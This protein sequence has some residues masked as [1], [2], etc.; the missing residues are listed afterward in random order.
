MWT[1][2]VNI[3]ADSGGNDLVEPSWYKIQKLIAALEGFTTVK[4][5]K[6]LERLRD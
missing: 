3:G 1:I 5:K 2:Q 4:L 6:N